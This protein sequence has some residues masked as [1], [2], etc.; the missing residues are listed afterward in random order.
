[1]INSIK[2]LRFLYLYLNILKLLFQLSLST[3][4][5]ALQYFD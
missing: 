5:A 3:I 4:V 1:M 2:L